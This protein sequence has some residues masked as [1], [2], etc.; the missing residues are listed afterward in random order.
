MRRHT[1]LLAVLLLV[2][3]L[4]LAQC[5]PGGQ[6]GGKQT[7]KVAAIFPG[8]IT[9]ADYNT[10]GYQ[11]LT[12]VQKDLGLEVGYSEKV[13][14]PDAE[15][16]M[17][18]YVDQGFNIIWTHGG[19]FFK[20][21]I[22]MSKE[23]PKAHFIAET[24]GPAQNPPDNLWVMDRNLHLPFYPLGYL[25]AKLTQT[26]KVG[27]IGGLTLP[28][29]YAEAHAIQQGIQAS[30][31]NVEF[32]AVWVGD[33]NDPAKARE[34]TDAMIAE[35]VDVIM[36]SLNLGM[37]GVFEAAKNAP[38]KVW[39]T[40]K[41]TD[42]SEFAPDNYVTS[43]LYDYSKPLKDIVQNIQG[44]KAGGYYPMGWNTGTTLQMPLRNV[45]P[46]LNA[47]IEQLLKDLKAG[48]IEVIKDTSPIEQ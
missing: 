38:H 42:K 29:S 46:E 37:L 4:T 48:K 5:A 18:E 19:Q 33:F 43:A 39:V 8:V 16:T 25:A 47:E 26:G 9:D 2:F 28:F 13:S 41:Y 22:A 36:G 15:R 31:R 40:A 3:A 14:V 7:Y 27:Y 34:L 24:D 20:A 12:S 45:P 30:G 10:L 21:T 1:F 35:G 6:G 11:A 23:Y 32:K 17:R 44:G